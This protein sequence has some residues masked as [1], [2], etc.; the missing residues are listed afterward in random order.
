MRA[1]V[2]AA[3][4]CGSV[5]VLSVDPAGGAP[6]PAPPLILETTLT[7][8]RVVGPEGQTGVGDPDGHGAARVGLLGNLL[9]HRIEV[10]AIDLP[11]PRPLLVTG[12]PGAPPLAV[13]ADLANL[14][15]AGR[16]LGCTIVSPA[17]AGMIRSA[18]EMV[19]VIVGDRLRGGLGRAD[20]EGVMLTTALSGA[21]VIGPGGGGA[22]DAGDLHA[23]GAATVTVTS[24]RLCVTVGATGLTGA[25]VAHLH[26]GG[27]GVNGRLV[28]ALPAPTA[29]G[30]LGGCLD[31]VPARVLAP[32]LAHPDRYYLDVHSTAYPEGAVRGNLSR[33]SV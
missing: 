19:H 16:A 28:L 8:Y 24:H 11:A 5:L 27:R 10:T 22:W 30:L 7:G 17:V 26:E 21:W 12:A 9:C 3:A 25:T 31:D 29:R 23:V 2:L 18:P 33:P 13:L 15:P 6:A 4:L 20:E 14:N 32:L 1:A